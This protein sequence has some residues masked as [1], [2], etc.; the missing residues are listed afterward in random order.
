MDTQESFSLPATVE[1]IKKNVFYNRVL[2]L[3]R[4]NLIPNECATYKQIL[5]E[6]TGAEI[7]ESHSIFNCSYWIIKL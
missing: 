7:K 6:I 1:Y 4:T 5:S 2:I 3:P